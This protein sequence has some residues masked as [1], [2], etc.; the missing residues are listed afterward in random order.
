M[1]AAPKSKSAPAKKAEAEIAQGKNRGPLHGIPMAHKDNYDT[2]GI[3]TTG[4]SAI[5]EHR[6]PDKDA[7]TITKLAEAGAGLL[8]GLGS[9]KG[10]TRVQLRTEA[11]Y[12]ACGILFGDRF[13][14]GTDADV[15]ASQPTAS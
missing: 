9:Q 1:M 14:R 2:K 3:T 10:S 4:N 15:S 13:G 6:V 11:K 5:Y 7:T 12:R 8:T